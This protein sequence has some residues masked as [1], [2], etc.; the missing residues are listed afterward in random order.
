M[1][2][3][4]WCAAWMKSST[5]MRRWCAKLFELGLMGIEIPEEYGGSGGSFFDA[6][7]AVETALGGRS[8]GGRCWWMCR[9][10]WWRARCCAGRTTEQ[11]RSICRGW[12]RTP[13]A[14]MR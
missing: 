13:W 2:L 6:V 4:R 1:K 3:R 11:K 5:W 7:L 9:T 14:R 12:R 8:G 10:R